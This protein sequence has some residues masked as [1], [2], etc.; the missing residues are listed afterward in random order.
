MKAKLSL[1]A[2]L[3]ALAACNKT[4]QTQLP[5]ADAIP[6]APNVQYEVLPVSDSGVGDIFTLWTPDASNGE[7]GSNQLNYQSRAGVMNVMEYVVGDPETVGYI[8]VE[9]AYRFGDKYLLVVS[10]GEG[11]TACPATTYAFTF[12]PKTEAVT[13]KTEIDGC[14]ETV[15]SLAEG[16]KLTVKK[17]GKASV[18]YNG[19]VISPVTKPKQ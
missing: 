18:F 1:V 11:G 13:G 7:S 10:T 12:N 2:I 15:E 4:P 16:N 14:A 17:D 8:S 6:A 3:L 19:E 5:V 9:K